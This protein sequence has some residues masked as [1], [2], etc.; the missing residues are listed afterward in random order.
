MSVLNVCCIPCVAC[1]PAQV[2]RK[3]PSWRKK[4][5]YLHQTKQ[6][7]N[8]QLQKVCKRLKHTVAE[9]IDTLLL[10]TRQLFQHLK[11]L[12]HT[13]VLAGLLLILQKCFKTKLKQSPSFSVT[14]RLTTEHH[15]KMSPV[16]RL[17]NLFQCFCKQY[18]CNV[19]I[20][21]MLYRTQTC[22]HENGSMSLY[23]LH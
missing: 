2:W 7:Y 19:A 14:L 3:S 15:R 5:S 9:Y 13:Q 1:N 12:P 8:H 6:F 4:P 18:S 22:I 23:H 17:L 11:N 16:I 10:L 20:N 21:R